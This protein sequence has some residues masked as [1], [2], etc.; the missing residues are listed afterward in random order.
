MFVIDHFMGFD[1]TIGKKLFTT[2]D[3]LGACIVFAM[4]LFSIGAWN[5]FFDTLI[6]P[7][8]RNTAQALVWFSLLGAAFLLGTVV[9]K[10]RFSWVMAPVAAFI[11]S[12]LFVQTWYQIVAVCIAVLLCY[13]SIFSVR[14]EMIDRVRFRFSRSVSAGL[15][16]FVLGLSIALSSAYFSTIQSESWEELVPRFSIGEG[17]ATFFIKTVAYV[18]PEW[19]KL[20][21]EG[22]TVDGFLLTLKKEDNESQE[23]SFENL[24]KQIGIDPAAMPVLVEYLR[25][26]I[27]TDTFDQGVVSRELYL[28]SGREQIAR[29]A[30]RSI[31]GE[32]QIVDI[33]SS[34]I[35]HKIIM[36]LSGEKAAKNLTPESVPLILTVLFF[37]TLLP[38]ASV[39]GY[40]W[41]GFS[42]FFFQI[43]LFFGWVQ[44]DRVPRVQEILLP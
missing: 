11:P 8:V 37:L 5:V 19:K 35:Q 9:W 26:N 34:A 6:S 12:L 25:N 27:A 2:R 36:I 32:E 7:N 4:G 23:V 1:I 33:F 24:G 3:I 16:L 39:I 29:L 22:M 10:E 13:W 31:S 21:D 44:L 18:Y 38:V 43:A 20:A 30:G 42:F 28:R 41:I 14:N 17:T 15:F 40:L